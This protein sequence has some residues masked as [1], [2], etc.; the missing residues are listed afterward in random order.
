MLK[1][2][3]ASRSLGARE[4]DLMINRLLFPPCFGSRGRVKGLLRRRVA[5]PRR[6]CGRDYR[7]SQCGAGIGSN[8]AAKKVS[9]TSRLMARG[10][11]MAQ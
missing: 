3:R 8:P 10:N 11:A 9:R 2:N 1:T 7:M 6:L 4:T 5:L